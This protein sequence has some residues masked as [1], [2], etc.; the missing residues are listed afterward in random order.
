MPSDNNGGHGPWGAPPRGNQGGGP[1][2]SS[3]D[4]S[5]GGGPR[6]GGPWG[7]EPGSRGPG[8]GQQMPDLDQIIA[9]AQAF[10]RRFLPGGGGGAARGLALV[11][12]G[13]AVLWLSSG[14]F[15][16]QPDELGIVLRFGAYDRQVG[17]G[18]NYRFPWP[19]EDV[20]KPPVTRVN[21]TEVGTRSATTEARLPQGGR[22]VAEESLMLTGDENIVDIDFAVFWRIRAAPDYLF[23]TRSPAG[24][25]KAVAE[26]A[27]REVIGRTPIQ[28]ALT[29][30]RQQIEAEV[31]KE[32]QAI[33]D[34]YRAGVEITQVQLQKVD[35]PN[36]VIDSFRDVQR[37]NTDA[38]RL[39]NE[40][41]SYRNDITPRA[42]GDVA[43]ILAEAEGFRQSTIA[44]ANGQAQRFTSVL[45]A[46]Q[47]AKDLTLKRM[48]IETMQDVLVHSQTVVVDDNVRGLVPFLSLG[49]GTRPAATPPQQPP[50]MPL[51]PQQPRGA[52]R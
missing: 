20:L 7:Q 13:A 25:V 40:A 19:V 51:Q 50:Q 6:P 14:L 42:R 39:R 16:V 1:G 37:A 27:M 34:Q 36:A 45:H 8:P 35:P 28:R 31:L 10:V 22:D 23:N 33:L 11:G 26:S 3:G 49:E 47:D 30:L 38:E 2:G 24:L 44:Q 48:Y 12:L 18:L 43:R 29:E 21:R 17:P 15:R 9:Q 5:G 41:E 52:N 32:T 4:G 46:Y